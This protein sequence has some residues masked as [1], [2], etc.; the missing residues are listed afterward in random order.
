M[1]CTLN[2]GDLESKKPSGMGIPPSQFEEVLGRK[3]KKNK[4][5]YDYLN[6]QDLEK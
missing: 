2:F 6:Y 3:L 1:I 5:K 4:N